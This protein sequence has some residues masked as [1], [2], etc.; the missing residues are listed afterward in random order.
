V[1]GEAEPSAGTEDFL[2]ANSE[3]R[4]TLSRMVHEFE[5]DIEDFAR[6]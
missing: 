4:P 3:L 1:F 6:F 5:E 2:L